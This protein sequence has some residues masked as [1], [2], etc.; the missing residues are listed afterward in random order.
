MKKRRLH[1]H[2]SLTFKLDLSEALSQC[3]QMVVAYAGLAFSPWGA[4]SEKLVALRH[5]SVS[6]FPLLLSNPECCTWGLQLCSG[7][8]IWKETQCDSGAYCSCFLWLCGKPLQQGVGIPSHQGKGQEFVCAVHI[9]TYIS[10]LNT[11]KHICG[12]RDTCS[13][14][15]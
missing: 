7:I 2:T 8:S 10:T 9:S 14:C 15:S 13:P 11:V 6:C 12:C 3:W 5:R 4:G 1:S